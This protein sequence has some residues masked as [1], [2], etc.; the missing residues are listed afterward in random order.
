[1]HKKQYWSVAS[2]QIVIYVLVAPSILLL[3]PFVFFCLFSP[4]HFVTNCLAFTALY[5]IMVCV[6]SAI[7][8]N[9]FCVFKMTEEGIGNKYWNMRWEDIDGFEFCTVEILK[10]SLFPTI[11]LQSLICIGKVPKYGFLFLNAKQCIFF[12]ASSKNIKML[13]IL[14]KNDSIFN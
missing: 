10:Y 1:M 12:S 4:S 7:C 3:F 14:S 8:H 5:V 2:P 11:H 13:K 6:S 9:A